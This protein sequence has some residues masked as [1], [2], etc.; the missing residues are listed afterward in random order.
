IVRIYV[1]FSISNSTADK[2]TAT[3]TVMGRLI[4]AGG[5]VTLTCSVNGSTGWKFDWFRYGQQYPADG[6]SGNTEPDGTIRVSEG[7][8][9][10]CRGG[11]GDPVSESETSNKVTIWRTVSRKPSLILEPN[12][13]QI[14]KGEKVTLTCEIQDDGGTQWT[15]EWIPTNGRPITSSEHKT[16]TATELD[17]GEYSCRGIRDYKLTEWS[18]SV[19]LTVKHYKPRATL[20]SEPKYMPAGGSVT[21][22]CSVDG[23]TG[24][25]F[26]WFRNG[27]QYPA[28]GSS[29]NTEPDG[30]IR[31]SEGGKYSCRGGRGGR[32]GP[33]YYS[34]NSSEVTIQ[35]TDPNKPSLVLQPNWSQI[36]RGE[37]VTL[38]CE[39]QGGTQWTYEWRTTNRNSPSSSEYK[40]NS[41]T[42]SLS[43]E[44]SCRGKREG[45]SWT[46]WSNV[47]NIAVSN[48][49]PRPAA[50]LSVNPDR[51]Q[52]FYY[53]PLSLSC[54]G[55]STEWRVKRFTERGYLSYCSIWG[56]MTGSTCTIKSHW[57]DSGVYWCES[58][59]GEFSNAVNITAQRIGNSIVFVN[60][61]RPFTKFS[62]EIFLALHKKQIIKTILFDHSD[63]TV[64]MLKKNKM[65]TE[66]VFV[67]D[68]CQY[69]SLKSL[70]L[71]TVAI[72]SPVSSSVPVMFIIGPVVGIL[73]IILLLLLW[74]CNQSKGDTFF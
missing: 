71:Q 72:T 28:D 55:N 27:Q 6:S 34:G 30:T 49:Y 68:I 22:T 61:F 1:L 35:I 58:G 63:H 19:T 5:S 7:G 23:S 3:L 25:K 52:H 31:V 15:Y 40:I 17:S 54:E 44:Y 64:T 59:S 41:A 33:V 38:R 11:R 14:Y 36:Y 4:P 26:D 67:A 18:D 10:S 73:L 53:D 16:I 56:T 48:V 65:N 45:F 70:F 21:L 62:I 57:F 66:D 74:R 9:Y 32:G 50:S 37:K 60:M 51:V 42:E 12:W 47:V 69:F 13:S 43:G 2:P 39:I 24:W 29:R 8:E 46:P 20:S